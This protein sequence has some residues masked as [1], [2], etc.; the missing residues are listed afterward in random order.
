MLEK[1]IINQEINI[2]KKSWLK[3]NKKYSQQEII[4]NFID[5]ILYGK[6][7]LPLRKITLPELEDDFLKLIDYNTNYLIKRGKVF[8]RYDYIYPISN[9]YLASNTIGNKASDFFQQKN[10]FKSD[11]INAPS[12]YR[13]WNT[14]K[15]LYTLLPALWTLKCQEVNTNILRTIISL[16]KYI[17][18]QFRPV[19]AKAIYNM[20]DSRKILDFSAGWGDRLCGFYA[21]PN[22]K[23]YLGI[24]PNKAVYENYYRQEM[25]YK[26]YVNN[27]Y[28]YFIN[29]PAEEVDLYSKNYFDTIFTSP[30]YFQVERYTQDNNQ[31]WKRYKKLKDWKEQFL[32]ATLEKAWYTLKKGGYL[33]V[34][35]SD[36]YCNHTINQICDDMNDFIRKLGSKRHKA[37]GMAM[38]K[39]PNSGAL[40]DKT[41]TFVEPIWIHQK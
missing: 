24:D 35:I 36:V 37:I 4:Q 14:E 3:L 32:F 22:T 28:S 16:R 19:I 7:D 30:P 21:S 11:S 12:P 26:R 33:I 13:T 10:R 15:F 29:S 2:N 5:L 9:K 1:Y 40:K 23:F 17:S 31:S 41:G 18:S 6:I 34:N 38:S 8:T 39:R 25:Y 20:F 27:K